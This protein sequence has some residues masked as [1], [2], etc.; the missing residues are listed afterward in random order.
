MTNY[1]EMLSSSYGLKLCQCDSAKRLQDKLAALVTIWNDVPTDDPT[2]KPR[3]MAM[4]QEAQK[5]FA[6]EETKAAY[7]RQLL[8]ASGDGQRSEADNDEFNRWWRAA[9]EYVKSDRFDLAKYAAERALSYAS[10]AKM[11]DWSFL[12]QVAS[13]YKGS[14]DYETANKYFDKTIIYAP[15]NVQA[16]TY[17]FKAQAL[18]LI[19]IRENDRSNTDMVQEYV[20]I[21][22]DTLSTA[23]R[24]AGKQGDTQLHTEIEGHLARF[25][26]HFSTY[27][28]D[29]LAQSDKRAHEVL[30]IDPSNNDAKCALDDAVIFSALVKANQKGSAGDQDRSMKLTGIGKT[31]VILLALGALVMPALVTIVVRVL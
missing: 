3:A 8:D 1:Y 23:S 28:A 15:Q 30:A 13:I 31:L 14:E 2:V 6:T 17:F 4:I 12:G 27:N 7:D 11:M 5:V 21:A 18:E 25:E 16:R 29:Y 26:C 9:D 22:W 24:M 10:N 19:C 20:P